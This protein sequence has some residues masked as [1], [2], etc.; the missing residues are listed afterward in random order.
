MGNVVRPKQ[1][2]RPPGGSNEMLQKALDT[3][4]ATLMDKWLEY[5]REKL[6]VERLARERLA[7]LRHDYERVL[8]ELEMAVTRINAMIDGNGPAA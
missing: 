6:L 8:T 4:K 5:E 1:W 3:A 7:R 2:G